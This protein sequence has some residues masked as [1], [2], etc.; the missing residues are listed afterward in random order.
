MRRVTKRRTLVIFIRVFPVTLRGQKQ[1]ES[2][3]SLISVELQRPA[4]AR[5]QHVEGQA[6]RKVFNFAI[7]LDFSRRKTKR[8]N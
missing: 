7:Q 1:T 5:A 6:N 4:T 8:K 2:V 3:V